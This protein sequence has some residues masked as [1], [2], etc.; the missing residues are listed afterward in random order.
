MTTLTSIIFLWSL[1]GVPVYQIFVL[2]PWMKTHKNDIW[3][4]DIL[5]TIPQKSTI[6]EVGSFCYYFSMWFL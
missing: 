1:L 3:L 5:K 2:R 4:S 6:I